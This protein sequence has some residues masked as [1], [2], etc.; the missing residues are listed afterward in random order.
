MTFVHPHKIKIEEL[1]TQ[2]FAPTYLEVIDE[3]YMHHSGPEAGS[4]YAVILVSQAFVEKKSLDRQRAVNKV[5]VQMLKDDIYA[6][7]L[8]LLTP[9][10]Y[11][12]SP[13]L[14]FNNKC[15]GRNTELTK[16]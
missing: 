13:V 11:A 12:T 4:H 14:P 16:K 10:E 8:R 1:L 5:L 7:S 9:E 2:A 3:S 15:L 6:L